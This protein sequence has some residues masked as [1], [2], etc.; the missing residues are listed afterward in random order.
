MGFGGF[1]VAV[2][3]VVALI[4]LATLR[5]VS[6]CLAAQRYAH[7]EVHMQPMCKVRLFVSSM[8]ESGWAFGAGAAAGSLSG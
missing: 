7:K 6:L 4:S 2:I 5:R 8:L 3:G 1:S